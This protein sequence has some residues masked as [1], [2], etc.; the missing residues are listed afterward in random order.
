KRLVYDE[1]LASD[2]SASVD[3]NEIGGKFYITARARPGKDLRDVEKAIDEEL[4]RFLKKGPTE[5]ELQRTKTEFFAHFIRGLERIGGFGGKSDILAS[6]QVFTGNAEN[7]KQALARTQ[8]AAAD[9]LQKA[10]QK[11]LSDGE[12]ILEVHPFPTYETAKAGVDRSK[13]PDP[14]V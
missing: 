9:Q 2:V 6:Y 14:T 13:L 4:D 11:W 12:Y 1:Q 5:D 3:L 10:A 7:Y 8:D